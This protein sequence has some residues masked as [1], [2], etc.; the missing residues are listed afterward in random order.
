GYTMTRDAGMQ[1]EF[2]KASFQ[3]KEGETSELVATDNGYH[4][5]KVYE[6]KEDVIAPLDDEKKE[7]I[8]D[9][10]LSE[11]KNQE[12]DKKIQNWVKKA[13]IRKYEKRL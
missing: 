2:L 3:L 12:I 8:R 9:A 13:D 1:P 5:I 6:A 11:K 10:L 7:Q 4:I